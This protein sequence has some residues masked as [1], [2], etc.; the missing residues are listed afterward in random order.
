MLYYIY[1]LRSPI[2]ALDRDSKEL[3]KSREATGSPPPPR[4]ER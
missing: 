2:A 1:Q 4:G 3:A